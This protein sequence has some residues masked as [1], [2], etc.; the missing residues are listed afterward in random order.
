MQEHISV[1]REAEQQETKSPDP[2]QDSAKL[3]S[4]T[5]STNNLCLCHVG[6]V[7]KVHP[8]FLLTAPF[9]FFKV[10]VL[11]CVS[12]RRAKADKQFCLSFAHTGGGR[13][14]TLI[15]NVN[16]STFL[17]KKKGSNDIFFLCMSALEVTDL[18]KSLRLYAGASSH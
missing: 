18:K 17:P 1:N 13:F 14:Q 5:F 10:C 9:F 11:L 8:L 16:V 4:P 7:R 6:D 2:L 3:I 12:V 15:M